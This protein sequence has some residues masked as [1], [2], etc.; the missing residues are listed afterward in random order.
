M[1]EDVE[2]VAERFNEISKELDEKIDFIRDKVM[3]KANGDDISFD[4][5]ERLYEEATERFLKELMFR[6]IELYDDVADEVEKEELRMVLHNE[7]DWLVGEIERGDSD[8][9]I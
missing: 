3:D 2:Y 7:F 8:E 6:Y 4:E 9:E 1:D 5:A